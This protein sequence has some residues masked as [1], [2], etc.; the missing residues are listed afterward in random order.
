[1]KSDSCRI[2]GETLEVKKTCDICDQANQF[3]CHSCGHV[4]T[5]QIHN[6]CIM[7]S[8]GHTLLNLK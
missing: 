1:M 4:T 2:C 5:E 8:F 7:T 6:Q 3:F